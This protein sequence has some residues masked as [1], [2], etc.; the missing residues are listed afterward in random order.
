MEGGTSGG[1][2]KLARRADYT[3]GEGA[4][5]ATSRVLT[6]GLAGSNRTEYDH[7]TMTGA[8]GF[9]RIQLVGVKENGDA[10]R[11]TGPAQTAAA[12]I[13]TACGG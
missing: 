8:G 5:E 9:L 6:M 4:R 7:L 13:L 11:P 10:S 1:F 3:I 12:E 2:V